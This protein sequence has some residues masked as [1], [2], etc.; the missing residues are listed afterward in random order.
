MDYQTALKDGHAPEEIMGELARRGVKMDYKAALAD[1]H[2]PME[3]LAEMNK[4]ETVPSQTPML[5]SHT[6]TNAMPDPP[7]RQTLANYSR[8]LFEG[9]GAAGGAIIGAGGGGL[10]GLAGGPAAPGTVPYGAIAGGVAGA[11][12]GYAAGSTLADIVAGKPAPKP[13]ETAG[14]IM[15]GAEMEMG[16]QATAPVLAGLAKGTGYLAKPLL[17]RMSGVGKGAI[18]E[19]LLSGEQTGLRTNPFASKTTFDQAMRGKISGEEVVDNARS[20]LQTIKD[21]RAAKYQEQL[22][23]IVG[24]SQNIDLR[25]LKGDLSNL[26]AKYNVKVRPDGSIDTSRIAM[27]KTG[28]NDIKEIIETVSAWGSKPEDTTPLGLDTLKRQLDDFYSDSSQA[29]Q[30]VASIRNKVKDTITNVVP[31]YGEMTKDYAEATKMIKDIESGLMMRKQGIS[32]RIVADQTLRRLT[33]SMKDNFA[34]R[35]ELVDTLGAEGGQDIAGQ[36]AGYSM[37]SP[38]PLGLAGT[39]PVIL[40]EAALAR[41]ISPKFI[42]VL[43]ASSPRVQGEFLRM[44][45]K[46]MAETKRIAPVAAR[47]LGMTAI[48]QAALTPNQ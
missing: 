30:F 2:D 27:G 38:I 37:R 35:R 5:P 3:V 13:G 41:Y 6:P 24:D 33:S 36:V 31:E 23:S 16:G 15:T 12:L 1:G 26:M 8:P 43:V 28:R 34:L 21:A 39:G 22:K 47:P 17:G 10:A 44:F 19:A 48:E 11:G 46:A 32:G 25:P 42:P 7:L 9:L 18:E 14:K 40:G 29:R 4:R 20:A 45:G